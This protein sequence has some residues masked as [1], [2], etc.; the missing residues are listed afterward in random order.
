MDIYYE[1]VYDGMSHIDSYDAHHD[2]GYC[3]AENEQER[4]KLVQQFI[5]RGKVSCEDWAV[6][7]QALHGINVKVVYPKWKPWA[8]TSEPKP[9]ADI[10][11]TM[12]KPDERI[13]NKNF[14]RIFLCRSGGWTPP[15]LDDQFDAF[16]AACPVTEKIKLDDV[17][18]RKFNQ[19]ILDDE[20][21]L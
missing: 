19:V 13:V 7:L 16:I 6:A 15:W 5:E 21:K 8:M 20:Y 3:G 17:T 14:H 12:D 4:N 2:G 18:N 10:V 1:Q 9:T 11:R